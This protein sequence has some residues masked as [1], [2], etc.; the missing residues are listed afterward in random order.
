MQAV[1]AQGKLWVVS[2]WTDWH[3][4]EKNVAFYLRVRSG[5]EHMVRGAVVIVSSDEKKIYVPHGNNGGHETVGLNH[6]ISLGYLDEYDIE[7][8]TWKV[9][10]SNAPNPRDHTRGAMIEGR[11]C[12]G[13]PSARAKWPLL[14]QLSIATTWRLVNGR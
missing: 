3:P 2:P 4:E 6:A 7:T 10:S 9:L 12:E 14:H 13:K 11:I 8:E 5:H 1:A